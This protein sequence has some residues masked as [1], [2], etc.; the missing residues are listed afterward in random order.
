MIT[1]VSGILVGHYTDEKAITGCTVIL[2]SPKTV[3]SCDVRGSAPGSRELALL[4]PDKQ[5]QEVHAILL[6]GGSAFGLG[7]A[8]G[9]MQY[10]VERNIGYQTPWARVP[11]I[12]SAV[13]FDLNVG[14]TKIFPLP[15]NA[16]SACK[17][18]SSK[19]EQG[20]VGAGAG[21]T[22]G[23]WNGLQSAMKGGVGS[24]SLKSGDVIVGAIAV[25]NAVGDV[26]NRDGSILAGAHEGGKFLGEA[27]RL[28][29]F[30]NDRNLMR[31][32]NT[33]LVVIATNVRLSKV[34]VNR[35]A[36]RAH[37]GIARAIIPSHTTFDG[38][39]T[40]ALSAGDVFA[41]IDLVAE[42]GA[43][44][45]AEAIRSAVMQARTMAGFRG[46]KG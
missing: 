10:L 33:T 45:T 15:E 30:Q 25:V 23:K 44:V 27:G 21:A 38:D 22:V 28:Q 18:A 6:T 29:S 24:T 37:D 2:C 14:D 31:N 42:M 32:T 34:D 8:N 41:P 13:I 43:E 1:D 46:L 39:T 9:V 5:M 17:N 16:Y 40:F 12:P 26:I 7:A 35:V 4:A 19:F 11:I 20:N 3:A 36:Q